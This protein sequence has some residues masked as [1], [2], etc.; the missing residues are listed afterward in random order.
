MACK[1]QSIDPPRCGDPS[2][3]AKQG[4][5]RYDGHEY[6]TATPWGQEDHSLAESNFLSTSLTTL[7]ATSCISY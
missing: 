1:E 6:N 3:T 4:F 5:R 2:R 7:T